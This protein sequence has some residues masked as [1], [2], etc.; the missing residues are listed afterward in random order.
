MKTNLW[1]LSCM[2]LAM[3][4]IVTG[5]NQNN[6]LGTPAPSGEEDVLNVVATANDFVSSDATSRVSETDYTTTFEEGDAIGVFVV[7]DGEALVSNMKMTLGADG[8]TW[9]GENDAKL[10]YYKDADYIAY[11]PYT[12]GLSVTSEEEI[13]TH[14]TTNLKIVPDSLHWQNTRLPI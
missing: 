13:I 1:K 8:T 2:A 9:A 14:F 12:E 5:C 4:A 3:A 6:E 11:S 10:Y 7:R